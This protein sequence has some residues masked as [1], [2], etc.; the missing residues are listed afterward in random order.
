MLEAIGMR[1]EE[2][3]G[4]LRIGLSRFTTEE[5][6]LALVAGLREAR[7]TLAHR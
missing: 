2:I 6:I 3:D 1:S 7:Q 4:A 5:D